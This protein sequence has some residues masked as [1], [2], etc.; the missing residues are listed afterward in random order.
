MPACRAQQKDQEAYGGGK[1]GKAHR[2]VR[3]AVAAQKEQAPVHSAIPCVHGAGICPEVQSNV[4]GH[5][6]VVRIRH[7]KSPF[8]MGQPRLA[9][10]VARKHVSVP[11]LDLVVQSAP[12]AYPAVHS[13]R[14]G[15]VVVRS[16]MHGAVKVAFGKVGEQL[17]LRYAVVNA[18]H[19]RQPD[20]H[21]GDGGKESR[22]GQQENGG[23]FD[24]E[25][26]RRGG[27][28]VASR[29]AC[30]DRPSASSL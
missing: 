26:V 6:R 5:G 30:H 7:R 27:P 10:I 17:L 22:H 14:I 25:R 20:A 4:F 29:G 24:G 11:V 1:T 18:V 23:C 8:Q 19:S 21:A 13:V 3:N 9:L 15:Q 28:P 16:V 2:H 12:C